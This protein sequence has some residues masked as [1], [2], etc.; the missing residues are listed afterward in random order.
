MPELL[1]ENKGTSRMRRRIEYLE[2]RVHWYLF[3]LD[4]LASLGEFQHKANVDR[5]PAKIF[6]LTRHYLK[7][8]IH[9]RATA[10][11]LVDEEDLDLVLHDVEPAAEKAR[12]KRM[13]DTHIEKGTVSWAMNQN[14]PVIIQSRET[15]ES[16]VFHV[17]ATK[18]EVQGMFLGVVSEK[19]PN[20]NEG[21][22]YLLSILMQYTANALESSSLYKTVSRQKDN[23]EEMVRE[24]TQ[25]LEDQALKLREEIAER[26]RAE[27]ERES[28]ENL[29]RAV[30]DNVMAGIIT[31]DGEGVIESFNSTAEVLFR[32]R[33]GEATGHN[34]RL[35]MTP[36][37]REKYDWARRRYLETGVSSV[38]GQTVELEGLRSDGSIFPMELALS[39]MCVDGRKKFTG[40]I[41]DITERK[42]SEAVIVRAREE[43]DKANKR[44]SEFLASMSHEIRTPMNAIIGMTDLLEETSLTSEQKQCVRV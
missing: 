10:F 38:I 24:R 9:F 25:D 15:G 2:K 42:E 19:D 8:L 43:A 35:L 17:L 36:A 41:R 11:Y 18:S 3:G 29:I 13:F 4:W 1:P 5:E 6:Q 37:Y 39:E 31:I 30:V 14:R 34:I 20:F 22:N 28:S 44:K 27:R 40:I 16:L 33:C 7:C 32:R 12:V 26:K 23:L 21:S